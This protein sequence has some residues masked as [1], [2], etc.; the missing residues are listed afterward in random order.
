MDLRCL[1]SKE[2][3]IPETHEVEAGWT[4]DWS[5]DDFEPTAYL[6]QRFI[7]EEAMKF[8]P[9]MQPLPESK[10]D[11]IYP[12]VNPSAGGTFSI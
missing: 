1:S 7:Y 4:V 5:F 11:E 3:H 2:L 9:E 10:E 12:G 8:H 6:L